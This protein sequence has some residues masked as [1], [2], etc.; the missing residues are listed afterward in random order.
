[1]K[2]PKSFT[3]KKRPITVKNSSVK[4]DSEKY[5]TGP[6]A[7]HTV[8]PLRTLLFLP[9][10]TSDIEDYPRPKTTLVREN[11][12]GKVEFLAGSLNATHCDIIEILLTNYEKYRTH[13]SHNEENK[14]CRTCQFTAHQL[15]K[16]LGVG[17]VSRDWVITRLKE[18]VATTFQI[19]PANP[20]GKWKHVALHV[21]DSVCDNY[22]EDGT[23]DYSILVRFSPTFLALR[24]YDTSMHLEKA[25]PKIMELEEAWIRMLARYVLSHEVCNERL[26][27]VFY[28]I[29]IATTTTCRRLRK[30]IIKTVDRALYSR[31][32]KE[33]LSEEMRTRLGKLGI[34]LKFSEELKEWIVFY[35][36]TELKLVYTENTRMKIKK[37]SK[38]VAGNEH[39][40][41]TD[42]GELAHFEGYD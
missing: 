40:S 12:K 7:Q 20:V 32:K 35:K 13:G 37:R 22:S 17:N 1:M 39:V 41:C 9:K 30:P 42:F 21:L 11:D 26:S 8:H 19:T 34:R 6:V 31:Y 23:D 4:E 24:E 5:V 38:V 14:L 25:H 28:H 10:K 3:I 18:M 33:I 16:D 27:S 29:G 2:N 15:A 36:K